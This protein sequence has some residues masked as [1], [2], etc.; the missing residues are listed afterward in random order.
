MY[1]MSESNCKSYRDRKDFC[2]LGL[3]DKDD[4]N[5]LGCAR[6]RHIDKPVK[7]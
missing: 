4:W 6:R 2:G 7:E 5:E 1:K 3:L